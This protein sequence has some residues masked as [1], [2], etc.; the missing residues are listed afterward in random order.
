ML[1]SSFNLSQSLNYTRLISF[2]KNGSNQRSIL[3]VCGPSWPRFARKKQS[4]Q[5]FL[6]RLIKETS[7]PL[8][9]LS[10][11]GLMSFWAMTKNYFGETFL[12]AVGWNTSRDIL[13]GIICFFLIFV[14]VVSKLKYAI[15]KQ[16][17]INAISEANDLLKRCKWTKSLIFSHV[18]IFYCY[19]MDLYY[20]GTVFYFL[21]PLVGTNKPPS[22]YRKL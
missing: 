2:T 6:F 4:E 10:W 12:F 9:P 20:I 19:S 1:V 5:V 15:W 16:I 13:Y 8:P 3:S 21:E 7:P 22:S 17:L 11:E 18:S 14:P